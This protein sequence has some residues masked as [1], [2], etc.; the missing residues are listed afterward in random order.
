MKREQGIL[1]SVLMMIVGFILNGFAWTILPGPFFNTFGLLAG[2]GLMFAG[3]VFLIINFI[4][5]YFPR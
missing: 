2:L 1:V 4:K 5:S 3:F